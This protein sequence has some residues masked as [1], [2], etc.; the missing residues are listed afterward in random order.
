[1]SWPALNPRLPD[2]RHLGFEVSPRG[3]RERLAGAY[4][5]FARDRSLGVTR[6]YWF[7]WSSSYG[8]GSCNPAP[9]PFEFVGLVQ[10]SCQQRAYRRTPLLKTYA[11][12]VRPY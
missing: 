7:S 3:Q 10:R 2:S 11:R 6:A 8:I 1:M 12:A 4:R 9:G 5:R